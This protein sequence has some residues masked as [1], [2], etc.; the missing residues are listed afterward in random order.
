MSP[1]RALSASALLTVWEEGRTQHP[2]DR[3]LLLFALAT[4]EAEAD[5]LADEPLGR[6]NAALL[7]LRRATFG[8]RLR[9]YRDCPACGERLELDLD[10][11]ALLAAAPTPPAA[12]ATIA[13]AGSR[14]R[15]PTSR[16]LA[17]AA[18]EG[19]ADSA[20]LRLLARCRVGGGSADA[21]ER[22]RRAPRMAQVEEALEEADPFAD[23]TLEL[24]CDPCGHG[25]TAP[26][27]VAAFLWEEV[28]ARAH[29]LLDEVHRLARAYGWRE[30]DVLALSEARRAAYLERATT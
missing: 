13:V 24:R 6:R 14:F 7:E 20:A 2:V 1:V 3:A 17:H 18:R 12:D 30:A 27:D 28:D 21:Q 8:D 29:G 11:A 23:L 10:A 4:P 5:T 9:A 22:D 25:W 16:D 15:L 19:D 26:F